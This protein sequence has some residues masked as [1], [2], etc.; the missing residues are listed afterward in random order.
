M[1]RPLHW[2]TWDSRGEQRVPCLSDCKHWAVVRKTESR[3][4]IQQEAKRSGEA[5][6]DWE[7]GRTSILNGTEHRDSERWDMGGQGKKVPLGQEKSC[8]RNMKNLWTLW[9]RQGKRMTGESYMPSLHRHELETWTKGEGSK[10]RR[11][12]KPEWKA[13]RLK[14]EQSFG[15]GREQDFLY[16]NYPY[17]YTCMHVKDAVP[18]PSTIHPLFCSHSHISPGSHFPICVLECISV[19]FS[20]ASMIQGN[21]WM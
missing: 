2:R 19:T 11:H 14:A 16:W 10:A 6:K 9:V 18:A 1:L 17:L 3:K 12:C 4:R 5:L 7:A 15:A 20:K 13:D 8:G 21:V